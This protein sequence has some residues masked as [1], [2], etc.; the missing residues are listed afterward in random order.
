MAN[1]PI[2]GSTVAESA[3]WTSATIWYSRRSGRSLPPGSG[4]GDARSGRRGSL[5]R[6]RRTT[7]SAP[8]PWAASAAGAG[9]DRSPG[10]QPHRPSK[11][12]RVARWATWV[13]RIGVPE[14]TAGA[15]EAASR[16]ERRLLTGHCTGAECRR[17]LAFEHTDGRASAIVGTRQPSV[18]SRP[19]RDR[20]ERTRNA[21][22]KLRWPFTAGNADDTRAIASD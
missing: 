3:I 12:R 9:A 5:P 10:R 15:N 11:T 17:V 18:P 19:S 6:P 4:R 22:E 7:G 20:R 8:A 21:R 16:E 2:P 14:A 13:E 1:S